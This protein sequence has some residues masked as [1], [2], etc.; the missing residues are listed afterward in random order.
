MRTLAKKFNLPVSEKKD[1]QGICFLGS[2][3]VKEFLEKEFGS[4][5]PALL[6]T[7]GQRVEGGY[8]IEKMSRKRN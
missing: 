6:Y 5:N 2:V 8:V 1:S 3:S 4:D 7:I